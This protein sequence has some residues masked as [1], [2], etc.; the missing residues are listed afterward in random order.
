VDIISESQFMMV[1]LVDK[2]I[3]DIKSSGARRGFQAQTER[4]ITGSSVFF[5]G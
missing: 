2:C 1:N 5:V 4:V 3:A